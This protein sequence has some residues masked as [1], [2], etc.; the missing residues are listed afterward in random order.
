MTHGTRYFEDFASGQ[1]SSTQHRTITKADIV[2][3]AGWSWDT[4]PV[5]SDVEGSRAGRFGR[6]IAHGLL[7][8]SVAMGLVS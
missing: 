4:N 5:H 8:M 2:S 7:G 3:F 6:P 1:E